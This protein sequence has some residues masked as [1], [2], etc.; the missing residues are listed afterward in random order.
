MRKMLGDGI[1]RLL[2]RFWNISGGLLRPLLSVC[3]AINKCWSSGTPTLEKLHEVLDDLEYELYQ[4]YRF[5]LERLLTEREELAV[6][7]TLHAIIKG[8][9]NSCI[10]TGYGLQDIGIIQCRGVSFRVINLPAF[11]AAVQ[12]FVDHSPNLTAISTNSWVSE[13]SLYCFF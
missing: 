5:R 9:P 4:D 1:D 10:T 8:G 11:D 2:N 7:K 3:N 13:F 12:C 6:K